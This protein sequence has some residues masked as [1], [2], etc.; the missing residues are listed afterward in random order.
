M[1]NFAVKDLKEKLR[2]VT[3]DYIVEVYIRRT[4]N[5]PADGIEVDHDSKRVFVT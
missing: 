1:L 3:D 5:T 4:D 2:D